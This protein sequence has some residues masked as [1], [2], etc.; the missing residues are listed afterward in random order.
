MGFSAMRDFA[1]REV[2]PASEMDIIRENIEYLLSPN[3][4][5]VV[6][7]GINYGTS[8]ITWAVVNSAFTLSIETFGG[9]LLVSAA[10]IIAVNTTPRVGYAGIMVDGTVYP[11]NTNGGYKASQ[12]AVSYLGQFYITD[13]PVAAGNHTVSLVFKV[14]LG[15]AYLTVSG[16]DIPLSL[17]VIEL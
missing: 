6:V 10:G 2:V 8:S 13:I 15:T 7:S 3:K 1:A 11:D 4:N 16:V 14:D 12:T 9:P 5:R 17:V